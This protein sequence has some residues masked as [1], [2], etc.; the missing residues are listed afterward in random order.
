M[1]LLYLANIR[2]PTEKAHGLQIMQNCEAFADVGAQVT[3]WTARRFNTTEMRG[4]DPFDFYGVS[5]NF[6]LRRIPCLDLMPL[7]RERT[8]ALARLIFYLQLLTFTLASLIEALFSSADVYYSRDPLVIL[9]LGLVKPSQALAYEAHDLAVGRWGRWLQGQ[10]VRRA[11]TIVPITAALRDDLIE[12][13][14]KDLNHL[15]EAAGAEGTE[16]LGD[17][18]ASA[19][20]KFFVAHD[21]IR[22]ARFAHVPEQAEARRMLGWPETAFI[23]GYVGR[24]HTLTMDKGVGVLVDALSQV[25]GAWLAVVG[26][27]D[28]MA[29]ALRQRWQALGLDEARFLYAGQVL[30]DRVPL[31]LSAF[32]LC[33]MPHPFTAHFARHTSPIKLFEYMASQR[34]IVASNL[35][36]FAEVVADGD[37]ALLVPPGDAAALAAAI[38]R[39][40]DDPALRQR[41][42]ATAYTEVMAHYT[43]EARARGI[44]AKIQKPVLY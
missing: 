39:L 26:G 19:V 18:R 6:V 24:L 21:G 42:S 31:Y 33:A 22:Q 12:R 25:K 3:L 2:V 1:K 8:D 4:K 27:P 13:M 16:N 35:P 38:L 40:K 20:Q 23:V 43:W 30:P 34:A 10:V 14:N 15:S 29:E 32:D 37:S 17:L 11:G 5:H 36:G 28:D 9:A 41:L 44:L 7:V